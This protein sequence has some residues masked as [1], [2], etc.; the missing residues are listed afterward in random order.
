MIVRISSSMGDLIHGL[1]E[2]AVLW[3]CMGMADRNVYLT[4][5]AG[6]GLGHTDSSTRL[7]GYAR[8]GAGWRGRRPWWP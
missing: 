6:D 2:E 4:L 3:R 5:P 7:P 1:F 8:A